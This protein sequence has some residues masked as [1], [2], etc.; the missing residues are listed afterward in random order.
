MVWPALQPRYGQILSFDSEL[1]GRWYIVV[2]NEGAAARVE[3]QGA[4][5]K[6]WGTFVAAAMDRAWFSQGRFRGAEDWA[7]AR[8]GHYRAKSQRAQ[9]DDRLR[10]GADG[11]AA[12]LVLYSVEVRKLARGLALMLAAER[13]SGNAAN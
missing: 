7:C 5:A 9:Y 8:P 4:P 1:F 6:A 12:E 2:G 10:V 13:S 3:A 11:G